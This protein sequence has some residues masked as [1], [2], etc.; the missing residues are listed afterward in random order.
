MTA[1][2]PSRDR[3][4]SPHAVSRRSASSSSIPERCCSP[5]LM[6][7]WQVVHAQLPPQACSSGTPKCF[8]RSRNDSGLPWCEYGTLPDSNSMTVSSPSMMNVTLGICFR[9]AEAFRAPAPRAFALHVVD[10]LA[11]QRRL[12]GAVHHDLGEV[13]RVVVQRVR[14]LLNRLA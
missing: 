14:P 2:Q 9:S 6:M 8:A 1:W 13:S 12:H 5:S 4:V 3:D 11:G 10:V 7:T